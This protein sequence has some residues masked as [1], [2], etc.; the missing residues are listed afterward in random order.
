MDTIEQDILLREQS[1]KAEIG[2]WHIF[3]DD[4]C[5][6]DIEEDVVL[7]ILTDIEIGGKLPYNTTFGFYKYCIP[8]TIENMKKYL[9][10]FAEQLGL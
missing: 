1:E 3:F 5:E 2:K 10:T 4:I 8:A 7:E 9:P 6:L